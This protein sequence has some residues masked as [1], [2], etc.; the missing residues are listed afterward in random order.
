MTEVLIFFSSDL[1]RRRG[2]GTGAKGEKEERSSITENSIAVA[3]I[4]SNATAFISLRSDVSMY[5]S[6]SNVPYVMSMFLIFSF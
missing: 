2:R 4:S 3:A 6:M 1:G 5:N